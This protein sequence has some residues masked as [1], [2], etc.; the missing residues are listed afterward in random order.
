MIKFTLPSNALSGT[1][2]TSLK[3]ARE[4][5]KLREENQLAYQ[6]AESFKDRLDGWFDKAK[7]YDN[8]DGVDLA[9]QQD[10]I[11][12]DR[13]PVEQRSY[14]TNEVTKMSCEQRHTNEVLESS[15]IELDWGLIGQPQNH[16]KF[17]Y[18][19]VGDREEYTETVGRKTTKLSIDHAKGTLTFVDP[20]AKKLGEAAWPYQ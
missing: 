12:M 3:Q 15:Y 17:G 16:A 19:R 11:V 5:A 7:S 20:F 10:L 14:S 8:K 2:V 1:P 18:K 13:V 9:D 6:A 4:R